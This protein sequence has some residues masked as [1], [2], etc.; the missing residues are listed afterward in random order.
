M[1]AMKTKLVL[2]AISVLCLSCASGK[3][4]NANG[5]ETAK[6][7]QVQ[8]TVTSRGKDYTI[9]LAE[10]PTT[11]YLWQ[12]ACDNPSITI[13]DSYQSD[14]KDPQI[15]GAGGKRNFN[16]Q[17]PPDSSGTITFKL[18]RPWEAQEIDKKVY[19]IKNGIL[20]NP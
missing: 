12:Y 11:G 1:E 13:T 10:N 14:R 9:I 16:V 19:M 5:L 2:I 15:M 6:E 7:G 17:C 20:I 18:K 8:K 3:Q 4:G